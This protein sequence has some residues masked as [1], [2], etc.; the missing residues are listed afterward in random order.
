MISAAR[1]P[2][3]RAALRHPPAIFA[4]QARRD[5][6]VFHRRAWHVVEPSTP[7]LPNWHTDAILEHLQALAKGE[8]ADLLI[9]IPPGCGKSIDCSVMFPAWLL[10]RDPSTRILC[11]SYA[12]ELALRDSR[13]TRNIIESEWYRTHFGHR[14]RLTGDQNTKGHFETTAQGYRQSTS[15]TGMGTGVRCQYLIVDDPHNAKKA[16]SEADRRSVETWWTETMPSRLNIGGRRLVIMQRLHTRDLSGIILEQGGWTHLSLPME[17]EARD[18][19]STSI[20]FSDPRREE[21]E[22]L[23]PS[24]YPP[25][26]VDRLKREVRAAGYAGQYQQ[27]PA[28]RGGG[29]FKIDR[30]VPVPRPEGGV[31]RSWVRRSCMYWDRAG[32]E[33]DPAASKTAGVLMLELNESVEAVKALG[34]RW[35]VAD[36]VMFRKEADERER[37]VD[38]ACQA[39]GRQVHY[40]FEQ[41][42]GSSGKDVGNAT[43]KRLAARGY[44]ASLDRVTG[45]KETRA[46]TCSIAQ[47]AYQIGLLEGPW[48][49]EYLAD[50]EFYPVGVNDPGDATAGA[51]TW[52][53]TAPRPAHSSLTVQ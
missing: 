42:P 24:R 27:R 4:E 51:F 8:I 26:E 22:L 52:L 6:K 11:A 50:M 30:F 32:T 25:E 21:G 31:P 17:F 43:V 47:N 5:L 13:H 33:D 44:R 18:R 15:V 23:W 10:A 34:I 48:N 53:T 2:L 49:E 29:M 16:L 20:G 12:E 46:E 7:L 14:V 41:E 45:D 3:Y 35:L 37:R 1:A 9:N 36:A 19:C 38:L 39:H 40:R 28:P